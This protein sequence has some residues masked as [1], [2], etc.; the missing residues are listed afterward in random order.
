MEPTTE[1]PIAKYLTS[2]E[3]AR[4]LQCSVDKVY[5]MARN[6]EIPSVRVGR[7]WRFDLDAVKDELSKPADSW[8]LPSRQR[9]L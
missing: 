4:V 6:R 8:A 7:S 9:R 5:R 1:S 3:L 2:T